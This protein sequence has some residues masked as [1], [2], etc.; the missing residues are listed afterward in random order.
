MWGTIRHPKEII[1]GIRGTT[2]Q[3]GSHCALLSFRRSRRGGHNGL[4]STQSRLQGPDSRVLQI[5]P[6]SL[7]CHHTVLY[8]TVL[9]AVTSRKRAQGGG[10]WSLKSAQVC[11]QLELCEPRAVT[12]L[13]AA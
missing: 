12:R 3:N 13:P 4:D 6:C 7:S 5:P 2:L 10:L 9:K 1:S 8:S 11:M